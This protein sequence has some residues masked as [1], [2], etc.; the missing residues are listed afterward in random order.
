V[1]VSDEVIESSRSVVI[2]QAG[3]RLW[4]AAAVLRAVIGV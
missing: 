3:N 1:V 2:D 4:T